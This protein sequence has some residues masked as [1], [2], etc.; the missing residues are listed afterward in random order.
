[1]VGAFLKDKNLFYLKNVSFVRQGASS[2]AS[3]AIPHDGA[4]RFLSFAL[5]LG[6]QH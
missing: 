5:I 1:M 2:A 3:S 4:A 6:K